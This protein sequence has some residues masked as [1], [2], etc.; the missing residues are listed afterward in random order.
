MRLITCLL[1]ALGTGV[2]GF[3]LRAAIPVTPVDGAFRELLPWYR[4]NHPPEGGRISPGTS[5]MPETSA[6]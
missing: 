2:A 1:L 6:P 5:N 4:A 3:A